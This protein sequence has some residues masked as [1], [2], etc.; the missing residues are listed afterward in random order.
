MRFVFVILVCILFLRPAVCGD[1]IFFVGDSV[2]AGM[3][4]RIVKSKLGKESAVHIYA[5]NGATTH[6]IRKILSVVAS[7]DTLP[8]PTHVVIYGGINDCVADTDEQAQRA[9]DNLDD[10]TCLVRKQGAR[11]LILKIH[12]LNDCATVINKWIDDMA[13]ASS[14]VIAIGPIPGTK[15]HPVPSSAKVTAEEITRAIKNGPI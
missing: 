12:V 14:D 11:I 8:R 5:K 7:L 3:F 6:E 13:I 15:V 2:T 9:I 4:P 10:M 1:V